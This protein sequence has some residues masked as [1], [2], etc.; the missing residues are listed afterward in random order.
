VEKTARKCEKILFAQTHGTTQARTHK[1]RPV[2]TAGTEERESPEKQRCRGQLSWAVTPGDGQPSH[3]RRSLNSQVQL[4]YWLLFIITCAASAWHS[5]PLLS[6]SRSFF[7][8]RFGT[9]PLAAL[10]H[11]S[12]GIGG[13]GPASLLLLFHSTAL[14]FPTLNNNTSVIPSPS[15]LDWS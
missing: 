5:A 2:T 8:E 4:D 6:S 11:P 14:K 9:V 1:I 10:G 15:F 12:R 13:D 3:G 7:Q